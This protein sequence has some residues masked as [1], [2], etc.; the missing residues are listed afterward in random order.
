MLVA[1]AL[2]GAQLALA[3]SHVPGTGV[4]LDEATSR[5]NNCTANDVLIALILNEEEKFCESGTDVDVNLIAQL[6]ANSADRWDIGYFINLVGGSAKTDTGA[7]DCWQDYLFPITTEAGCPDAPYEPGSATEDPPGTFFD[8]V[9]GTSFHDDECDKDDGADTC[10]DLEQGIFNYYQFAP[11]TIPC[12]DTDGDGAIDV[13]SCVSWDNT[14]NNICN[15]VGDTLPNTKAKCR[16]E[17]QNIGNVFTA[18]NIIVRK[19]T[20]PAGN[21]TE[22]FFFT[23]SGPDQGAGGVTLPDDFSLFGNSADYNSGGLMPSSLPGS[24]TYSVVENGTYPGWEKTGVV[25]TSSEGGSETP[26]AIDLGSDETVTCVFTNTEICPSTLDCSAFDE[27]CADAV[28]DP[29]GSINNCDDWDYHSSTT[30]CRTGSGDSCDDDESCTG[31]SELCPA[32]VVAP[33]TTICRTGSGDSCD[34]DESCTGV[35]GAAC[36]ADVIA[37][38]TTI[39]R[40]GSGDSC[41]LDESCT[42]VAGAACPA[43]VVAPST[44]ICRTGS[45]DSCDLDESCTGVAGAACP[46]DVIAPSTTI[47]RTGSGD[48]CD[49]DESC[50]GVAGAACPA[51]VVAPSTTTCRPGANECDPDDSCT[52]VPG[53]ACPTH[54]PEVCDAEGCSPGFWKNHTELW[55]G[56]SNDAT[57]AVK[58]S[59]TWNGT[60]GVPSC[61]GYD[62]SSSDKTLAQTIESPSRRKGGSNTLF[63]LT[64]CLVSSDALEGFPADL[65]PV[66]SLIADIQFACNAGGTVLEDLRSACAAANE[67]DE[68]TIFCPLP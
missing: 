33:S 24:G 27:V 53:A 38:S 26:T 63:H 22:E 40:T 15:D 49:L 3:Q 17:P 41:D 4:C 60:L 32:D 29:T 35:P 5:D 51:D 37:P 11:L 61:D 52:G 39:C 46:A 42:G 44:T 55:D 21:S 47:C 66:P 16:C 50:T 67:H 58:T 31:V 2:L 8:I 9:A 6:V 45:G 65:K 56:G 12:V 18:G 28:C 36:P 54:V 25:C 43:D 19:T 13:H 64:A 30:I 14:R 57:T 34:L 68:E 59:W 48:L 23:L 20:V 7:S 62:F 1:Y 10:G